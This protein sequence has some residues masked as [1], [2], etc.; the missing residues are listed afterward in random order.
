[1]KFNIIANIK[2]L[3]IVYD[4]AYNFVR[5]Y[6]LSG[7]MSYQKY[8]FPRVFTVKTPD[9]TIEKISLTGDDFLD[10]RKYVSNS[11]L[12][13]E[14]CYQY[15]GNELK[16]VRGIYKI[17]PPEIEIMSGAKIS[18]NLNHIKEII[19]DVIKMIKGQ[20]IEDID[21][22]K[23]LLIQYDNYGVMFYSHFS[24]GRLLNLPLMASQGH[25]YI[26]KI[27]DPDTFGNYQ[28]LEKSEELVYNHK[29]VF[30]RPAKIQY[31]YISPGYGFLINVPDTMINLES[32]DHG[33]TS[34]NLPEGYYLFLHSRPIFRQ[35]KD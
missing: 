21:P 23:H 17:R 4:K 1:M 15:D 11:G 25:L 13:F 9:G 35:G 32:S 3:S 18:R 6:S 27:V 16:E 2:V 10:C 28:Y 33:Q 14:G 19:E 34:I 8:R 20:L 29:I 7:S 26:Y 24:K 5:L 30:E 31:I 22:S 12:T